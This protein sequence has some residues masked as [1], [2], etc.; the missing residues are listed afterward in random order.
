MAPIGTKLNVSDLN[1][2][3]LSA[4]RKRFLLF[5]LG[6]T[7]FDEESRQQDSIGEAECIEH[8]TQESLKAQIRRIGK[9][10][11][12]KSSRSIPQ[13]AM[14]LRL[15]GLNETVESGWQQFALT[16]V[17]LMVIALCNRVFA[18]GND[19]SIVGQAEQEKTAGI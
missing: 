6:A 2:K 15:F 8:M 18:L 17:V 9:L 1:T 10:A 19:P 12:S 5:L 14:T 4:A 11:K 16:L 7:K 3:K 13:V